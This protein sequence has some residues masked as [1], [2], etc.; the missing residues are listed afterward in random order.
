[1]DYTGGPLFIHVDITERCNLRCIHCRNEISNSIKKE[2][3]IEKFKNFIDKCS[4]IFPNFKQVFIG[5]G[6]PLIRKDELFE[7]IAYCTKK[8]LKCSLNT[9]ATLIN[10]EDLNKLTPLS[11]IQVSLDGACATTHDKIR[12][13]PG[14]FDKAIENIKLLVKNNFYV[15]VRM[16]LFDFNYDEVFDLLDICKKLGVNSFSWF[17]V[18]PAGKGEKIKD[19]SLDPK[20]YYLIMKELIRL[21]YELKDEIKI[22][23]SEPSKIVLDAS[24]RNE[25][26]SKYG[27]NIVSGCIPGHI[28]LFVNAFGDIYPCTMLQQF[29]LGNILKDNIK[30]VWSNSKVL[31]D[32]R[33]RQNLKGC[34]GICDLKGLCG[35]CRAT[36]FGLK[37]DIFEEDPYCPKKFMNRK[38]KIIN[39]IRSPCQSY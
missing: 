1:M 3:P 10:K 6:E 11:A 5:G 13:I 4:I 18:L 30:E 27:T 22:V 21:K 25:I 39:K 36:A 32:L 34:C 12:G 23:S 26:I 28:E 37:R 29:K 16:T 35:G 20:I 17:R 38:I 15:C 31:N 9:N 33:N 7:L 8:D 19:Y 24:L 2:L 14:S